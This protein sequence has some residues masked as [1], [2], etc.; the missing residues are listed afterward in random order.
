MSTSD[1]VVRPCL[2]GFEKIQRFYDA[3]RDMVVAKISPGEF[4]VTVQDEAITTVLGSCV[5]A[6]IRDVDLN[7]GGI[8]HFML[9]LK[10]SVRDSMAI[11]SDS[12]RY[13]NW[14]ME[15]LINEILK[16]GGRRRAL[17]VKIFGGGNVV[18]SLHAA[19]IGVKNIEF[20]TKYLYDENLKLAAQDVGGKVGRSIVYYP[21]TGRAQVKH[22][23]ND[24]SSIIAMEENYLKTI[25]TDISSTDVELF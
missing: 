21:K 15:Y 19:G 3:S 7:I 4:Y 2:P 17:E 24:Q 5:S 9:P 23:V 12:F 16:A 18:K 1:K 10:G 25:V 6:C 20:I 11:V 8:N 14:A 13:G 22:L